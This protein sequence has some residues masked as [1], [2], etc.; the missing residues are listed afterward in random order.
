MGL[1]S[2]L[3]ST[4]RLP[5]RTEGWFTGRNQSIDWIYPSYKMH[6]ILML[7]HDKACFHRGETLMR[8]LLY[9]ACCDA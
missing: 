4:G 9:A 2:L 3:L 7:L 6:S 1:A 5:G 8:D